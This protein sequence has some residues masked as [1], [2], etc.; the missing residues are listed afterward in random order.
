MIS[1]CESAKAG[2]VFSTIYA[3]IISSIFLNKVEVRCHHTGVRGNE[4]STINLCL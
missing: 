3:F 4:T 1:S 2:A